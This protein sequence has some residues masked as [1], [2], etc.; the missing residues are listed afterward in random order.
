MPR[1]PFSKLPVQP[2]VEGWLIIVLE[3]Q[4]QVRYWA[5]L[6]LRRL[7]LFADTRE[8]DPEDVIDLKDV[9][10]HSVAED[11]HAFKR[12]EADLL[13]SSYFPCRSR[14]S[15]PSE[16]VQELLDA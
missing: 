16:F 6:V 5:V 10:V 12:Y 14:R 15:R 4:M 8:A 13:G 9:T 3:P 1:A 7:Y 2:D 11:P